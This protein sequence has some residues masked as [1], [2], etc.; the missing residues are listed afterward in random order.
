[1][2]FS[3]RAVHG[4]LRSDEGFRV[5]IFRSTLGRESFA[6]RTR[7][8]TLSRRDGHQLL[9]S[10]GNRS[11]ADAHYPSTGRSRG[12]SNTRIEP[13]KERSHFRMDQLFYGGS[14]TCLSEIVCYEGRRQSAAIEIRRIGPTGP[15]LTPWR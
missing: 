4:N 8:G 13:E 2:R 14:G 1:G 11:S 5:V 3:G 10:V 6:R 9:R 12:Y 7:D 15:I